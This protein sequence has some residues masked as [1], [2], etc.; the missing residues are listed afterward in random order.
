[1]TPSNQAP[2]TVSSSPRKSLTLIQFLALI[3]GGGLVASVLLKM[4]V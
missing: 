4:F 1:M 3:G 2:A